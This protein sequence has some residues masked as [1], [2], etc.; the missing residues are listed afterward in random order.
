MENVLQ[1]FE[2]N[3]DIA[4]IIKKS[5]NKSLHLKID[6]T[7]DNINCLLVSTLY[8]NL[9]TNV[10]YIASNV[11]KASKLYDCAVKVLGLDKVNLYVSNEVVATE[12]DAVNKEFLYERLSCV[13]EIL[14]GAKK[15]IICDVNSTLRE[16]VPHDVINKY[17]LKLNVGDEIK[18]S[19]LLKRLI[20][21]G[22]HKVPTTTTVGDFSV[23]GEIV[24]IFSV[25]YKKPIRIDFFDEEIEKITYFDKDSQRSIKSESINEIEIMPYTELVYDAPSKIEKIENVTDYNVMED[26]NNLKSYTYNERLKKYIHYLYDKTESILD[27]TSDKIIILEDETNLFGSYSKFTE[28]L[29]HYFS[30]KEVY[31]DIDL[32]YLYDFYKLFSYNKVIKTS[33]FTSN[34]EKGYEYVNINGYEVVNYQNNINLLFNDLS[35]NNKYYLTFSKKEYINLIK[36]LLDSNNI[37]Y[38]EDINKKSNV[39]IL[40]LEKSISFGIIGDICLIDETNIYKNTKAKSA[41]FRSTS[42][43]RNLINSKDDLKLGDF[44][45]HYDYGIGKYLGIKTVRTGDVINDYIALRFANID[46]YIPVEKINLIEKYQAEEGYTPK[47]STV[48]T[49]EWEKKKESIKEKLLHVA[50]DLILLQAYR[51]TKEG[52]KYAKDNEMQ[53]EFEADFD[54]QETPDQELIT[55]II[56][57]DMEEGKIIDRLVCGDVGYGKTEIAMRIAF[58][59]VL[60][61]KQV[62]YL[63]PTTILT[64]Q[65]FYTFKERMEKYGVNVA[66]YNRLVSAKEKNKILKDLRSGKI[67][68]IIGT[69]ALLSDDVVYK[70][71]GLLIVDEEQRFGVAHKEKIKQYKNNINVI[72]LTATPIPRTLQMAIM[73]AR[74]LSLMETPP[75][76]RYPIQTYVLEENDAIIREAI[77]NELGRGGQVFFLH[78]RVIDI[79]VIQNKIR[80]LVPE[81]RIIVAHGQ[82][83]KIQLENAVQAFIDHEYDVLLCTTIIETGIDIPNTNTLIVEDADKLGLAQMYQIRGRVGRTNR[84]SY[85]YFMYRHDTILTQEGKQRLKVIKEFTSFGSGFKIASRDLAIRGA[86]DFLGHEQSGYIDAIGMDLYMKMLNDCMNEVKGIKEDKNEVS[87]NYIEVSKHVDD[88]YV[89]DDDVKIYIHKT[90]D[91]I[92]SKEKRDE[93][94]QELTD[95]F[96]KINDEILLYI[97]KKYF[98]SL[99]INCKVEDIIENDFKVKIVFSKAFSEEADGKNMMKI[100]YN[101][102]E[103]F[104]IDYKNKRFIVSIIKLIKGK[105][106]IY[107]A[108]ELLEEIK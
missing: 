62:A 30:T 13:N 51:D 49:K 74:Q 77:Y 23:R 76:N 32:A 99:C 25:N 88:S 68:I 86:G 58:K 66:L 70:D 55:R 87:F 46:L 103:D 18:R 26:I 17:K 108:I 91:T 90:I 106:W 94:I 71:L 93:V 78:N 92:N 36:E 42:D 89:S 38:E 8:N 10:F 40:L 67:D 22:Y 37:K 80:R 75:S 7:T 16:L 60:S 9:N 107:N 83:T 29:Y 100:I 65:H 69:H 73:G 6:N 102:G 20:M 31:K 98:D 57:E 21:L 96:G 50:R 82:M 64:R 28:E 4:S 53:E 44:V 11:Y 105:D 84:V 14:S 27:Y 61:S 54:Y 48:G 85:A 3:K 34:D 41:I 63:A 39:Y 52:F 1:I 24:D 56:K 72:T 47:L 59:T 19:D 33:Y 95:R 97:N 79:D 5:Q 12:V 2:Q 101:L 15:L 43:A 81:A 104:S 35:Q 45:V